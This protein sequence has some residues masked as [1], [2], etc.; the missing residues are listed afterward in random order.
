MTGPINNS[1]RTNG[2]GVGK[3]DVKN[4]QNNKN[5]K[6]NSVFTPSGNIQGMASG[7]IGMVSVTNTAQ[8]WANG[9]LESE[10]T[11]TSEVEVPYTD[12]ANRVPSGELSGTVVGNRTVSGEIEVTHH[13]QNW[14]N[15]VLVS[16][17]DIPD[18]HSITQS[19]EIEEPY[20][21]EHPDNTV[22]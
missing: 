7:D 12:T 18:K 22:D 17:Q 6:L 21:T 3:S 16:E 13:S 2:I 14:G 5:E 10:T 4:I 1:M 8:I 11:Y 20:T 19:V 9:I 15:G